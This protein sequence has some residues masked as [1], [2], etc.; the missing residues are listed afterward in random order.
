[1]REF[2][3]GGTRDTANGKIH[4]YGFQHPLCD[5]SFGQYMLCHQV[6]ADGKIRA[7]DNWWYGWEK[8]ISLD[9]LARHVED[10]K[11]IH[12]GYYVYKFRAIDGET[13]IV[14]KE[15]KDD[16]ALV[17]VTEEESCNAIRFNS[18]SYLLQVLKEK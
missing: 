17:R 10:L 2:E 12:A 3:T 4:Y 16:P 18:Q 6:Q 13:T 7:A 14:S 15:P 9:S 8:S 5:F 1:M 11:L